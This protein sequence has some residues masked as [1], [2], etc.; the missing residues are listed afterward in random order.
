[1]SASLLWFRQ[2]LR[3]TDN[4]ALQAALKSEQPI[5]CLYIFDENT[6]PSLGSAAKWWLHHSLTALNNALKQRG[7]RLI[8][9]R[10]D[11][12][13]ILQEI[14]CQN[15]IKNIFWNRMYEPAAIERDRKIKTYWIAQSLMVESFNA[16]LIFEPWTI[17]N[18]QGK[19]YQVF[20]PFWRKGCSAGNNAFYKL[21]TAPTKIPALNSPLSSDNL[22]DWQLLP[23][24]LNWATPFSTL[25]TPGELGAQNKLTH[26]ITHDLKNYRHGRDFPALQNVSHLSPH[27]HWGEIAVHRVWDTLQHTQQDKNINLQN[28]EHFQNELG[29]REFSYYLL[30]HFPQLPEK[31]FK[32]NLDHFTWKKSTHLLHAWQKGHTGY[33]IVD[34]GMRE[35]WHTGFMHNRVRMIVASFLVKDLLIDW[36]IGSAWFL[37]TLVDADLASNSMNWQW[38]AGCGPDAA[39]YFRIFNPVQQ[40]IKFDPNG[41]YV[42]RW[43]PEIKNLPND[44]I[45]CPWEAPDEV[46][47]QAKIKLGKNYAYPL[48]EHKQARLIALALYKKQRN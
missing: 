17:S 37:D 14:I 1:M 35:L 42:R 32:N 27:L 31:N 33:P 40:G 43:V 13:K 39:P 5:I 45:H 46:L 19:Y 38:V 34:A 11:P 10:G 47:A 7:N 21:T 3:L 4:P 8:L 26:F 48:V 15:N 24:K 2:D 6:T 36:R 44:Y 29:W 9:R 16:H 22:N 41:D 23:Q 30:Y 28:I 20:T 12:E 25:W 18:Q